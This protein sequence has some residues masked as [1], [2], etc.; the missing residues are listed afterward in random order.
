MDP[1]LALTC[2]GASAAFALAFG[3]GGRLPSRLRQALSSVAALGAVASVARFVGFVLGWLP[4][5][6]PTNSYDF[7]VFYEAA[8]AARGW[9]PL[10][11]LSGIAR[12]PGQIV[13]YRHAPIGAALFIPWT[14]L[15]YDLALNAWRLLNVGVY[16]GTLL[17]FLRHCGL[18]PRLPLAQGLIA[19]WFASTPGRDSLGLGQWDALFLALTLAALIV[20]T[21]RRDR[22]LAV[23]LLLAL[24]VALKFYPALLLLAPILARRWR[25]IAGSALGGA[26]VVAL[27]ALLAGP[28]NSWVFL[29]QVLP[30][31]GGGTLYAE[32]QTLYALFGR[33]LATRITPN[34]I[35]S[36]YPVALT[37]VLADLAAVPL[38]IVTGIAI[39]RRGGGTLTAALRF[40]LPIP[41]ALLIIPT[42]WSHYTA[43]A[44]LPLALLAVALSRGEATW[45]RLVL[46]AIAAALLILGSERDLWRGG[47][48]DGPIRLFLT[49]KA[50]GLL[51]LWAALV[52]VAWHPRSAPYTA[53][54][55]RRAP[56]PLGDSAVGEPRAGS[57]PAPILAVPH[58]RDP[59]HSRAATA[60][61]RGASRP[62]ARMWGATSR[63][64]STPASADAPP[65]S[66]CRRRGRGARAY[67]PAS[68]TACRGSRR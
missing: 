57:D 23:G 7:R 25:T 53:P 22:D 62:C 45:P 43:W 18:S 19:L 64:R 6:S 66:S 14:F 44:L 37:G 58:P 5:D 12:D 15:P 13:V 4:A 32:N 41:V 47:P 55:R 59:A 10:Y 52:L 54:E 40:V 38:V 30:A 68:G 21:T 11:D 50:L 1:L 24:P 20:Y 35:G 34:G 9:G 67:R 31:V 29:I 17:A 3:A 8:I 65:R 56:L 42:A 36:T 28:R 2:L 63:A 49:Y 33:L 46:F 16:V 26:A 60:P 39:W 61:K 48:Y 51:A 27:G